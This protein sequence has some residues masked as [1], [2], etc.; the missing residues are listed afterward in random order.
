MEG[1]SQNNIHANPRNGDREGHTEVKEVD[2]EWW[3][4]GNRIL[5]ESGRTLREIAI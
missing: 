5:K 2:I 3:F 4:G 1:G